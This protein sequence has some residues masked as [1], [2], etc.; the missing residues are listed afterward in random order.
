MWVKGAYDHV[1]RILPFDTFKYLSRS[2]KSG[3]RM[4]PADLSALVIAVSDHFLPQRS[5]RHEF[6]QALLHDLRSLITERS[7]HTYP[8]RIGWHQTEDTPFTDTD[9]AIMTSAIS[10]PSSLLQLGQHTTIPTS[11]IWK[12]SYSP[13]ENTAMSMVALTA[14]QNGLVPMGK[15]DL[16]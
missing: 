3:R 16:Q 2:P 13:M 7:N 11:R 5:A 12:P 15:R 9:V 8:L 14:K 4:L 1:R 10:P 6:H